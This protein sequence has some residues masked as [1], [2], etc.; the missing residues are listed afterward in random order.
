MGRGF[1]NADRSAGIGARGD[2]QSQRSAAGGGDHRPSDERF[3]EGRV[4]TPGAWEGVGI[5]C[6]DQEGDHVNANHRGTGR[7]SS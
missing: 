6:P 4:G 1:E 7:V 5:S 2:G 3:D